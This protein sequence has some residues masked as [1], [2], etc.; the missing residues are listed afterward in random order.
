MKKRTGIALCILLALA[1]LRLV[2]AC[3]WVLNQ[4]EDLAVAL[5]ISLLLGIA[6]VIPVLFRLIIRWA[7]TPTAI[8]AVSSEN[9][10]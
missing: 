3:F 2:S 1:A 8:P 5:G 4:P 10:Q 7:F 6:V 9:T